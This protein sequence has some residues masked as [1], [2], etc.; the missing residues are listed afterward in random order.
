MKLIKQLDQMDCGPTCLKMIA[1]HYGQ[2]VSLEQLRELCEKGQQGVS[3]FGINAAAEKLGFDASPMRLQP[4]FFFSDATLPCIVHWSGNHYVVVYKIKRNK[5]YIADPEVGKTTLSYKEFEQFWIQGDGYGIAL[6][7]SPTEDFYQFDEPEHQCNRGISRLV[8]YVWRFK[9]LLGQLGLGALIGMLLNFAMPFL[10]QSLVDYGIGNSDINFLYAILIAQILL[11]ISKTS[12]DFLRSWILI[13]VGARINVAIISD[14]LMKL[15]RLPI[16]YFN[17]RNLGD[18][19]QRV[20]DHTKIEEF[21][22]SHSLN[23]IFSTLNIFMFSIVLLSYSYEIFFTFLLG[24]LL[25]V[26]WVSLFLSRRRVLDY[27]KFAQLSENQNAIVQLVKGMPEI[28]LN[29]DERRQQRKWIKIQSN[30][31]KVRLSALALEQQQQAGAL[32]FNEGKNITITFIAALQVTSGE[33]SL[34]M[35]L[36]ISYIIGQLNAPI[37]QLIIFIKQ[38][39]DAKISM[40]RLSE[41]Q[42]M[43]DEKDLSYNISFNEKMSSDIFIQNLSF[44]YSKYDENILSKVTFTIPQNK[45]TAIVGSSGSGKTTLI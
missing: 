7:L 22:T 39:Q 21:L 42:S 33:M 27:K 31:F 19:L 24:T 35:M 1:S 10:T 23:I 14:F 18:V 13:H 8:Q 9:R 6:M 16:S 11:F 30:L 34:G 28:R 2:D 5:V 29:H 3:L 43:K 4:E 45:T 12:V 37:E 40:E 38:A 15:M 26:V 41:I 20:S 25:A 32:F 36:A 17:S 44:K